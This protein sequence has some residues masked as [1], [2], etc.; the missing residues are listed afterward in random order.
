MI[1]GAGGKGTWGKLGDELEL[2]WVDPND[3]NY[4]SENDEDSSLNGS[5]GTRSR[6][7]STTKLQPL[8]PEMSEEDV[9]KTVE[10]LILEYF[11]NNDAN[12]VLFTLQEM[13]M[14]LGGLRW[15]IVSIT[16]ELAMD[17]KPSH[18]EMSSVLFS[19]LYQ[20]VISQRDIGKGKGLCLIAFCSK[21]TSFCFCQLSTTFCANF[22]ISF[23]I[24][25][26]PP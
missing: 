5:T 13:L 1:G 16:V 2:P 24:R 21:F 8:V 18:R 22:P 3:P 9:R 4:D 12:E 6:K 10:P 7:S 19:E 11:E 25:P 17:H 23:W 20:K 14:N 15:M 26:K